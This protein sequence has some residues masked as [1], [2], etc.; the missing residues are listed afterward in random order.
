MKLK[1][2][3]EV[4]VNHEGS[5]ESAKSH[6]RA[7]ALNGATAVK[8]QAY[9]A[10][11]LASKISPSYWDN[12][13]ERET[14]QFK[15]FS[16]YDKFTEQD[17]SELSKVCDQEQVGFMSTCFDEDWIDKLDPLIQVHK[18]ASADI[19]NFRLLKKVASKKK[20]VLLSTGASNLLEIRT[21]MNLL[22]SNGAKTVIPMHCVLC[23]PTLSTNANLNRLNS[24][25]EIAKEFDCEEI[26]YS[27]HTVPTANHEVLLAAITLGA[28]WIEKHFSLTPHLEGNDHYHSFG[29]ES[30]KDFF[31]AFSRHSKMLSYSEDDFIEL[32]TL[33]RQNARRG[34]YAKRDLEV[35]EVIDN[36]AVIE[37]RPVAHLGSEEIERIVGMK[38]G[39]SIQMGEPISYEYLE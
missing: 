11:S 27:D 38:V 35:G 39:M 25:K 22:L 16:K 30:L 2:I 6:I 5:L 32:Q 34:L 37:L 14:S 10:N 28:T 19:T 18:V 7:A 4:G 20:L 15:L 3:A 36:D 29:P 24:L 23:Y 9:S 17:Y 1:F 8:F 13:H 12:S 33:A 26:G 21:A 31:T